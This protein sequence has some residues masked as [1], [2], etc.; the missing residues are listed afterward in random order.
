MIKMGLRDELLKLSEELEV[1]SNKDKNKLF[2]AHMYAHVH[3]D[4]KKHDK[5]VLLMQQHGLSHGR[6]ATIDY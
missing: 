6:F 3:N 1:K 2:L 4:K 5:I